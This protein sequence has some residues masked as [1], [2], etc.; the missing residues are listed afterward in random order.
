MNR[1]LSK[2][3]LMRVS[4]HESA[5]AKLEAHI[6]RADDDVERLEGERDRLSDRLAT[7]ESKFKRAATDLAD[8]SLALCD[9]RAELSATETLLLTAEAEIAALRPDA[10]LWRRARDRRA[11]NRKGKA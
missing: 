10:L 2:L 4:E 5:I 3:G 9:V 11:N 7:M 6:A 8:N 1:L